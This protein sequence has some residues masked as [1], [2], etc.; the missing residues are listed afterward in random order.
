MSVLLSGHDVDLQN[1]GRLDVSL[2][3]EVRFQA[4]DMVFCPHAKRREHSGIATRLI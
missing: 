1:L 2:Q 4:A 3:H